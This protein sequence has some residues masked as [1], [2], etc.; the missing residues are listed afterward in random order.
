MR[1]SHS[2]LTA[3]FLFAAAS[4]RWFACGDNVIVVE[5]AQ[6][7]I[8]TSTDGFVGNATSRARSPPEHGSVVSVLV[9]ASGSV[10]KRPREH[11]QASSADIPLFSWPKRDESH[12]R[13]T[14]PRRAWSERPLLSREV[15]PHGAERSRWSGILSAWAPFLPERLIETNVLNDKDARLQSSGNSGGVPSE[16]NSQANVSTIPILA[17][18]QVNMADLM[19]VKLDGEGDTLALALCVA[20]SLGMSAIGLLTFN[21][22]GQSC[23]MVYVRDETERAAAGVEGQ[24]ALTSVRGRLARCM[25]LQSDEVVEAVGL[26]GWMQIEFCVLCSKIN[27]YLTIV[28]I[29]LC[30]L[31]WCA[32]RPENTEVLTY[33]SLAVNEDRVYVMW[34]HAIIVWYVVVVTLRLLN[35][36]QESFLPLRY[37]WL[38]RT[39]APQATTLLVQEIPEMYRCD[40]RLKEH[41][42][43]LFSDSSILRCHV[44]R[45]T[46]TLRSKLATLEKYADQAARGGPRFSLIG[47]LAID[48]EALARQLADARSEVAYQRERLRR[49]AEAFDPDCCTDTG[50]VTFRTRRDMRIAMREQ[51]AT[52]RAV[53]VMQPAPPHK[54]ITFESLMTSSTP[55]QT[56][57][58]WICI[59]GIILCFSPVVVLI[60][61]LLSLP[62]LEKLIPALAE[63]IRNYPVMEAFLEG[64]LATASLNLLMNGPL[65]TAFAFVT[66][67]FFRPI[68]K[69]DGEW[70]VQQFNFGFLMVFVLLVTAMSQGLITTMVLVLK[71][72]WAILAMLGR[73]LPLASHFYIGYVVLGWGTCIFELN[74]PT[75]L[76]KYLS[77]SQFLPPGEAQAKA[78][79]ESVSIG[80]RV[81]RSTMVMVIGLVFSSLCPV[82]MVAVG[83]HFFVERVAHSYLIFHAEPRQPDAGGIFWVGA[84][85]HI[86]V[87]LFVYVLL[88][89]GVL[90]LR[91][92]EPVIVVVPLLFYIATSWRNFDAEH[93]WE[94]LPLDRLIALEKDVSLNVL[95]QSEGDS[96]N[97]VVYNQPE[98]YELSRV[99][100]SE[101][102]TNDSN[103]ALSGAEEF[104]RDTR[105]LRGNSSE[106]ARKLSGGTGES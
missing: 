4:T 40:D 47:A 58:G 6:S 72:P 67:T 71:N 49:A 73:S 13:Y 10:A 59:F 83:V 101:P 75:T 38:E 81:S 61:G 42:S 69:M 94:S 64:V 23:P 68:T 78:E 48:A 46:F 66:S 27:A 21:Y 15:V 96:S 16:K 2:P 103:A 20:F 99:E 87:G 86:H 80:G 28:P 95:D 36:A 105:N 11:L 29:V 63:W 74:R 17:E 1:F 90:G 98:C 32:P 92:I 35:D 56:R 34:V 91:S 7:S 25:S 43:K 41:F 104:E 89:I 44:V 97:C 93:I 26:D 18:G 70:M 33:L 100:R 5:A 62:S 45:R 53:F 3:A 30:P 51:L 84:L 102:P 8:A 82:I 88:M 54:D 79:H 22:L 76:L 65:P 24:E 14:V 52:D 39:P 85:K 19:Q 50:F 77:Y 31:H 55:S 60:S 57:L 37:A 9:D 106:A 12:G